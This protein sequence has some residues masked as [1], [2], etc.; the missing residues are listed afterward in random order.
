[1]KLATVVMGARRAKCNSHHRR[2]LFDSHLVEKHQLQN[3]ALTRAKRRE[4]PPN[5]RATLSGFERFV[6]PRESRVWPRAVGRFP[7]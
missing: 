7:G 2:C 3:L 1:M 6:W 5:L 4:R